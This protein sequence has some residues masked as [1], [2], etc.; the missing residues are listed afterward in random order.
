MHI[1]F[2]EHE[3]EVA[4]E[5]VPYFRT[6]VG[7]GSFVASASQDWGAAGARY[8]WPTIQEY[9]SAPVEQGTLRL[10]SPAD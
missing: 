6:M 5:W 1:Y 4:A 3:V 2:G 9:L 8:D 10:V 7:A